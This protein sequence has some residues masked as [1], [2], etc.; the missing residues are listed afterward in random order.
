MLQLI[1]ETT[2]E[3]EEVDYKSS[4]EDLVEGPSAN[5]RTSRSRAVGQNA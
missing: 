3:E 2:E 4:K 5:G 1:G